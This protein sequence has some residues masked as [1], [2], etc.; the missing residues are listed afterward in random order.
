MDNTRLTLGLSFDEEKHIY[1][2]KGNV[3]PSV[4]GII[5]KGFN[6]ETSFFTEQARA[7]GKAV[8][9]ACFLY[10]HGRLDVNSLHP[11]IAGFVRAF[12]KFLKDT[13]MKPVLSL[14]EKPQVHPQ[15]LYCGTPDTLFKSLAQFFLIEIKTG[16]YSHADEQ[17][18]AYKEFP[19]IKVFNPIR[20]TLKL[21][22]DGTYKLI[23]YSGA[24]GWI[25]F[26]EAYKKVKLAA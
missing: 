6:V 11:A 4:T 13:G 2:F 20:A 8:H 15:Y 1:T 7:R 24:R 25:R 23:E 9:K 14:C 12:I 18:S 5:V 19:Q 3:I 26:L 17:T 10:L 21:N 22:Q 16:D